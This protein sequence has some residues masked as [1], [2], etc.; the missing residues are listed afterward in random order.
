MKI[1]TSGFSQLSLK[2]LFFYTPYDHLYD[3]KSI[4]TED[5]FINQLRIE[6]SY[7][8]LKKNLVQSI[9][10]DAFTF[11]C[12]YT[13]NG[14]TTFIHWFKEQIKDYTVDIINVIK[15]GVGFDLEI[16]LVETCLVDE[17]WDRL[18]VEVFKIIRSNRNNIFFRYFDAKLLDRITNYCQR[19]DREDKPKNIEL[20]YYIFED[21]SGTKNSYSQKLMLYLLNAIVPQLETAENPNSIK[22]YL[23]CFDNLDELK[24][25]HLSGDVWENTLDATFKLN[26]IFFELKKDF[27][28]TLKTSLLLVFREANWAVGAAQANDRLSH[29]TAQM[30]FFCVNNGLEIIRKRIK[31]Y[32]DAHNEEDNNDKRI[33]ELAEIIFKDEVLINERLMPLFNYDYRQF[34][35][36]LVRIT[37]PIFISGKE[38][39]LFNMTEKQYDAFPK[40]KFINGKRGILM[41][42]FIRHLSN[43]NFLNRIAPRT[44]I[45][46]TRGHCNFARMFLTVLCNL[47]FGNKAEEQRN[48]RAEAMPAPVPLMEIYKYCKNI[49]TPGEFF[50]TINSLID[51]NRSSWTHLITLYNKEPVQFNKNEYTFDFSAEKKNLDKGNMTGDLR[52]I[53]VSPNASAYIYLRYIITH[54]EYI[55]AHKASSS[56]SIYDYKPL[57]L[58][59]NTNI[60]T[61]KWEFEET[62]ETVYGIVKAYSART[63]KFFNEVF[64]DRL[65][66]DHKKYCRPDSV[67]I[68]K[69]DYHN[70][71]KKKWHYPFYMTRLLTTHIRYLDDFRRYINEHYYKEMETTLK[72]I[73]NK[74]ARNFKN[75]AGIN[76]FILEYIGK[77]IKL[78]EDIPDPSKEGIDEKL[79]IQWEQAKD[80]PKLPVAVERLYDSD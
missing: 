59:T 29:I 46:D 68:F 13:G 70:G 45:H 24:I 50:D 61:V 26:S 17:L 9:R 72:T 53:A 52:K 33:L 25:E 21:N 63:E 7:D 1:G 65:E 62:I 71:S 19:Y 38:Y 58:C 10:N 11:L 31:V 30:H 48:E 44:D 51:I 6:N 35:D 15:N 5:D 2:E 54:F 78:L 73:D 66:Y 34:V 79:R 67:Y 75:R 40:D 74:I 64:I 55:A 32:A 16:T 20:F 69:G 77:Y 56:N 36:A 41:H 22:P 80:N 57:F 27:N 12:G 14:K 4:L 43:D 28:Y 76:S 3:H 18:D 47:A 37:A 60:T 8:D 49:M 39:R 42:A 23:L